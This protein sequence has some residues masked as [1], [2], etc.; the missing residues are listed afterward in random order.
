MSSNK[1]HYI[2]LLYDVKNPVRYLSHEVQKLGRKI[3]S[4]CNM[5]TKIKLYLSGHPDKVQLECF[6]QILNPEKYTCY[7][8]DNMIKK[9]FEEFN[10]KAIDRIEFYEANIVTQEV[11]EKFFK[12]KGIIFKKLYEKDINYENIHTMNKED[13]KNITYDMEHSVFYKNTNNIIEI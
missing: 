13:I 10:L 1:N 2:Y 7:Q 5:T 4:T 3:S 12:D 6:Y 11:L 9:K 8:I